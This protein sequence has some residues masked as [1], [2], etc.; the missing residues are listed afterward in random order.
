MLDNLIGRTIGQYRVISMIAQGGMATVYLAVHIGLNRKIALKVLLPVYAQN[1]EFVERFQREAQAAAK[2]KH[3]NII[4]IYDA[5]QIEGYYFIAMEYIE[6]GSL[7]DKVAELS[8]QRKR[9]DIDTALS[10]TRQ[11]AT[12]LDYAHRH[13]IIHRDVKPSNILLAEGGR[14]IL[15]DLGIAKAVAGTALT[16]TMMAVGTPQY[17]SPEQ[18][19]GEEIDHRADIYSLGVVLY[20][21]LAGRTPFQADTP[22]AVIHQHVYET[23]PP[24]ERFNPAIAPSIREIVNKAIAKDPLRRY[25][26][27]RE[28]AVAL[29]AVIAVP[30]IITEPPTVGFEVLRPRPKVRR[31][32]LFSLYASLGVIGVAMVLLIFMVFRYRSSLIVSPPGIPTSTPTCT[33]T[34]TLTLSVTSTGTPPLTPTFTATLVSSPTST[35]TIR[36]VTPTS[37]VTPTAT[38]TPMSPTPTNTP[39]P[40]TPTATSAQLTPTPTNTPIPPTATPTP[41]P[42]TPTDT[43][44]PPTPTPTNTPVPPTPTDT[45]IPV[46]PTPTDTPIPAPPTPTDTPIPTPQQRPAASSQ[47]RWN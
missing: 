25:R 10:I 23:P 9:M 40:P 26:T 42:P 19:K 7:Q 45:P 14:A 47:S 18:G 2:L 20:E 6:G 28:M 24:L 46:P 21:M 22:W 16:K 5:G 29:D 33:V 30:G 38:S 31:R 11:I 43:P 39:V 34:C 17:M 36:V 27:A 37:T 8:R 32:S 1:R 15:T 4:Q 12:A 3:P 13:G 44:I 41:V 35:A